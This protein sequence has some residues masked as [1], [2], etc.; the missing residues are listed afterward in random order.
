MF[1]RLLKRSRSPETSVF[2]INGFQEV[3][4]GKRRKG[5]FQPSNAKNFRKLQSN[6]LKRKKPCPVRYLK[7]NRLIVKNVQSFKPSHQQR[8]NNQPICKKE[9]FKFFDYSTGKGA[10]NNYH[11]E[12]FDTHGRSGRFCHDF[13]RDQRFR[14]SGNIIVTVKNFVKKGHKK[15]TD[16][17]FSK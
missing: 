13:K 9:I 11:L 8:R 14:E 12:N 15:P 5:I 17:N 4:P 10:F 1:Y 7:G 2:N 16:F 3:Y 6:F